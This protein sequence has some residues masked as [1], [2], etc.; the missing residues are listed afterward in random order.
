MSIEFAL[1]HLTLLALAILL[2]QSL[3][4]IWR[5]H[6]FS[7]GHHG[8]AAIGAYAAVAILRLFTGAEAR[9][10]LQAE[11]NR[12][13][14]AFLLL[15][16]LLAAMAAAAIAA[17][18][19]ANAF[20][21]LRGDYFAVATLI[22]AEIV[23]NLVANWHF[24]GGGVGFE[25]PVLLVRNGGDERTAFAIFYASLTVGLNLLLLIYIR[26]LDRSSYGLYITAAR[27]DRLAAELAGV[28]VPSLQKRILIFGS[29]VAGFSGGLF[30]HFIGQVVPDD[31]NFLNGLPIIL[32]VV[33]GRL[34]TVRCIV[35]AVVVYAT[36]E[37]I[38]LRFFGLFGDKDWTGVG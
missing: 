14:G 7:L 38:K 11:G 31:F 6:L 27:D 28:D 8:F 32:Y 16:S 29:A 20:R 19:T 37:L 9:W 33:L 17:W 24:V 30:L 21:R 35:A 3:N 25:T 18:A 22:G 2:T 12:W 23:R 1:Y 4:L 10:P 36:F 26:R 13:L 5:V 15:A 34:D